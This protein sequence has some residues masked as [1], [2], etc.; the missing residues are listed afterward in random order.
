MGVVR[1]S[2]DL[3]FWLRR[4]L[5]SW[6]GFLIRSI[7]FFRLRLIIFQKI[8]AIFMLSA[9]FQAEGNFIAHMLAF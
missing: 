8:D 7:L 3:A 9:T 2:E 4:F 5:R 1:E 6:L